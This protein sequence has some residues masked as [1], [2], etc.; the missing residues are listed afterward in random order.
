L[1][2]VG[3]GVLV[4]VKTAV[5]VPAGRVV[6]ETGVTGVLVAVGT[7]VFVAVLTGVC[8]PDGRVAVLMTVV[9]LAGVFVAVGTGV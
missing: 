3:T 2:A 4:L 7:G 6:V 5:A 8:V 1:V 9:V